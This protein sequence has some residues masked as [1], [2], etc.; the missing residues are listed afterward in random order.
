MAVNFRGRLPGLT[1]APVSVRWVG[2]SW[3]C[4]ADCP[5]SLNFFRQRNLV[6]GVLFCGDKP[7]CACLGLFSSA[8]LP[9]LGEEGFSTY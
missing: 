5:F 4:P 1:E 9:F 3:S 2:R 7:V 6:G 8:L